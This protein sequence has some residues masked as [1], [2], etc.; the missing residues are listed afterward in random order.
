MN[1]KPNPLLY[2]ANEDF[3]SSFRIDISL[4][5]EIDY[6][7]LSR[8]VAAAME[9]YPYFCVRAERDGNSIVL[10]HN[11]LPVPVYNDARCA[12]L[13]SEECGGHLLTFGCEGRSIYLNASHF[14]ADGMGIDPLLKTVLYLYVSELYGSEGLDA[15]KILMPTDPISDAEYAYPFPNEP[16]EIDSIYLPKAAPCGVYQLDPDAFEGGGP[17]A[18]HLHI[19]QKAMMSVANPSDGSPISFLSVMLYRA[20]CR[21]DEGID[22]PIV[23]HVQHQYRSALRAFATRHS[24]VSYIPVSLSVRMKERGVTDQ[25]TVVRGQ[26]LLGSEVDADFLAVNRMLEAFPDGDEV[27]LEEKKAAMRK[28]VDESILNKTFGISYV[29]KMNWFGLDRYVEDIHAYIGEKS[30]KNML[31][32]EVM[33]VGE[34]F[35]L[36]FM[37]SGKGERYVKA[38]VEELCRLDIPVSIVGESGYALSDTR[39]TV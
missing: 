9:R 12:V 21:L 6:A 35:T 32:I 16:I 29:G 38:F 39:L 24:M 22:K 4:R 19:P 34:D 10:R 13:G 20:L 26:I 30:T 1:Y 37:Q 5:S 28:F 33:T 15:E 23:A 3:Y 25:N 27:S 17:Y 11:P 7:V 36:N 14:I 8:A 31:L 2:A 18:Y